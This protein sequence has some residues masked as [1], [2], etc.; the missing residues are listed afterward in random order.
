MTGT[1]LVTGANGYI[2]LHVIQQAIDLGWDVIGTVRSQASARKVGD[3]FPKLSTRIRLV[4]VTDITKSED[5]EDVFH[6]SFINAVI[7]TASPLINDPNDV[8]QEV[9]DPAIN[10]GIAILEAAH[11]YGGHSCKRVV[12]VSSFTACLNLSLGAGAG[13]TYTSNDW[14][15]MTYD[16]AADGGNMTAYMGSKALAE[17]S[18][19]NWMCAHEPEFDLVSVNPAAVFGPHVGAVELDN[20]NLSTQMLWE[21]VRPSSNPP[22]YNS[23]HLG[24]WVDVRDVASALLAAVQVPEAGGKRFLAAQRC[25]WQLIRD[26]ARRALPELESLIDAG[27]PGAWKYDGALTYDVN[28]ES[29]TKILGIYYRPLAACLRDTYQQLLQ[30]NNYL[31]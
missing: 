17:K 28:G 7:N 16:E 4:E 1:I 26:E 25:H 10:S 14:N 30:A 9:L 27:K 6:M 15:P 11:R 29:V 24:S 2:A 18:M 5:F 12:H 31:R 20:L 8:R 19:W 13:K 23:R 21:L 22:V 3:A